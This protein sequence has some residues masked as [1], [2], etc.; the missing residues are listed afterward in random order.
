MV[1]V[2]I[3][4]RWPHVMKW[5]APIC[6]L[7]CC[8]GKPYLHVCQIIDNGRSPIDAMSYFSKFVA[9]NRR[10]GSQ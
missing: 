2:G 8:V 6:K 10:I 5:L 4:G 9:C 1:E 7:N 3:N